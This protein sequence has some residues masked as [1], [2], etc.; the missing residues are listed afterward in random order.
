M[1]MGLNASRGRKNAIDKIYPRHFLATAR[2]LKFPE[3]QMCEILS[4]FA[5][6]IPAALDNVRD[7]LPVDF[8]ENVATAIQTNVLR[9]HG[10]LSRGM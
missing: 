5:R 3:V 1:A 6:Q 9:L 8:P 4:E 2:A 7:S 10:R